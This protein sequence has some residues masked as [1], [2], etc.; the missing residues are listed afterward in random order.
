LTY[1]PTFPGCLPVVCSALRRTGFRSHHGCGA[2]GVLHPSSSLQSV[3]NIKTSVAGAG[4]SGSYSGAVNR[5]GCVGRRKMGN[6]TENRKWIL[7]W[8]PP[9]K[10]ANGAVFRLRALCFDL[11]AHLPGMSP[12]GLFR[13]AADGL[14]FPSRLRGSGGPA[15]LFLASIR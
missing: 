4:T 11:L 6:E 12:S 10:H 14:S 2:A 8:K 3:D 9:A 15:P 7:A 13:L 5:L 1:L